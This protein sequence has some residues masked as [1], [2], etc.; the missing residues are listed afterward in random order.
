M[1]RPTRVV[2]LDKD[3]L[4][5]LRVEYPKLSINASVWVLYYD[6]RKKEEVRKK[7]KFL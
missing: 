1:A 5:Q 2:R 7:R 4:S 6:K 3:L